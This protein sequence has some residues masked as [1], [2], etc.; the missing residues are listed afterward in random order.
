MAN[1]NSKNS[2]TLI[3]ALAKLNIA[4]RTDAAIAVLEGK[5]LKAYKSRLETDLDTV[6]AWDNGEAQIQTREEALEDA[7]KARVLIDKCKGE[8]DA[9]RKALNQCL[10]DGYSVFTQKVDDAIVAYSGMPTDANRD[11]LN[12]ALL[13][14]VNSYECNCTLENVAPWTN[15]IGRKVASK[16][17]ILQGTYTK[18]LKLDAARKLLV[19]SMLEDDAIAP[20]IVAKVAK[21]E[22]AMKLIN[23]EIAKKNARK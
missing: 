19:Y 18:G 11:A 12:N 23:D 1:F 8:I 14:W 10:K 22:K 5:N 15:A 9:S 21:V 7:A 20:Y 2:Q 13:E 3:K 6:K 4:V 16:R 17:D